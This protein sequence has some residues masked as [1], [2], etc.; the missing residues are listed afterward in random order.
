MFGSPYTAR[1]PT[2][3]QHCVSVIYSERRSRQHKTNSS[4]FIK[5][6]GKWS[7]K[8]TAHP[9]AHRFTNRLTHTCYHMTCAALPGC[10]QTSA[11]TINVLQHICVPLPVSAAR[12]KEWAGLCGRTEV[13]TQTAF[14][15]SPSLVPQRFLLARLNHTCIV[16]S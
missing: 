2:P 7:Q 1:K 6:P 11:A 8:R 10:R 12:G 4:T 9:E 13:Q 14:P 5:H 3:K 15:P 16:L